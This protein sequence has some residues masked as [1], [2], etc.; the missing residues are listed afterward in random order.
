MSCGGS[1][2]WLPCSHSS[3]QPAPRRMTPRAASWHTVRMSSSAP[4]AP[5]LSD[6]G[7]IAIIVGDVAKATAFYRDVLGLPLVHCMQVESVPSTGEK[8]P[9]AHI[10]FEMGDG[11]YLAFFDL[12]KGE[13]PAPSPNTP[14]WVQHFA[15]EVETLEEVLSRGCEIFC[16]LLR[17]H[18]WS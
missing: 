6:I 11:S 2:S 12:G 5:A 13:A 7:Q 18:A 10:F 8:G 16:I 1:V 9:Y 14:S 17:L 15:M 4:A 3:R